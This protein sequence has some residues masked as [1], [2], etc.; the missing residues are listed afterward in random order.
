MKYNLKN[1]SMLNDQIKKKTE[2]QKKKT[3][4]KSLPCNSVL[5]V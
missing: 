2:R 3:G 4:A 1:H 5:D